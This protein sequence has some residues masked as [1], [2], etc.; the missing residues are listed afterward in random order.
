MSGGKGKKKFMQNE[1][2]FKSILKSKTDQL[3]TKQ[4]AFFANSTDT[5]AKQTLSMQNQQSCSE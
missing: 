5:D 3:K 2:I 4:T 1:Q